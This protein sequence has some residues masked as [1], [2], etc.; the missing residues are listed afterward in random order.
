MA[1]GQAAG[2]RGEALPRLGLLVLL[3]QAKRTIEIKNI[4]QSADYKRGKDLQNIF[5]GNHNCS[6]AFGFGLKIKEIK[7][8]YFYR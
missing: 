7:D 4:L 8:L 1:A 3:G 6:K 2:L 5:R